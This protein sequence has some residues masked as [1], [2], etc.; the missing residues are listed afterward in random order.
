MLFP[1]AADLDEYH[2][3]VREAEL[4]AER[5]REELIRQR[6]AD[7]ARER[8]AAERERREE[9]ARRKAE[10]ERAREDAIRRKIEGRISRLLCKT[11]FAMTI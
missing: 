6:D 5:K 9:I 11:C 8:E 10:A 4:E 1:F 2:R 3:Q 7:V